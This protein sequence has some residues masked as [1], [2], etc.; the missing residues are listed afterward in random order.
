[1][2]RPALTLAFAL[3]LATIGLFPSTAQAGDK[4]WAAAGKIL[5]GA[6][7]L[8]LITDAIDHD[9]RRHSR[10]VVRQTTCQPHHRVQSQ[11]GTRHARTQLY[12]QRGR[13]GNRVHYVRTYA[14]GRHGNRV[15]VYRRCVHR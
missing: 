4:E 10:H 9:D 13:H 2:T 5:T 3:G 15:I 12:R 6:I 1:M 11:R 8:H 14:H 7:A